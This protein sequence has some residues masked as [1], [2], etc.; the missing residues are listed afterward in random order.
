MGDSTGNPSR[1]RQFVA[2]QR[3]F[4]EYYFRRTASIHDEGYGE[5][6]VT[7]LECIHQLLAAM[8]PGQELL[9]AACGTG[10]YFGIFTASGRSVFGIDQSTEMLELARKKWPDVPTQQM[11]LQDLHNALNW[12]GRFSGL[13]CI[14]AMEWVLHDDWPGV[15]KGFRTILKPGS[16][17]YINVELTGHHKRVI[18]ARDAGIVMPGEIFVGG[19]YNCLPNRQTVLDWLSQVGFHINAEHTGDYYWHLLMQSP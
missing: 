14:D 19:C 9:D 6:A 10:K 3:R 11:A 13:V 5:I 16:P 17:V 7:H 18:R 2:E 4:N 12:R 15:L 1:R 8:E